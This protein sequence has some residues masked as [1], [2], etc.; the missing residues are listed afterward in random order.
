MAC[1]SVR[2]ALAISTSEQR[3]RISYTIGGIS[4]A[5]SSSS[6]RL[7]LEP[8][9]H[10]FATSSNRCDLEMAACWADHLEVPSCTPCFDSGGLW[11][12]YKNDHGLSFYF[13]TAHLGT[14]PYKK[15]EFNRAFTKGRISLLKGYFDPEMPIYPLEYPLDELL[16]IHRLSLGFGAEVHACGVLTNDGKGR[17]F[18]GHSGAGKSTTSRLWL[19]HAGTRI[20]SDD[21]IILRRQ[22]GQIHMYG[23][24]WHGDAGLAAQAHGAVDEIFLLEHGSKNEIVPMEKS[25]AAAELFAR[26]FVPHHSAAGLGNTLRFVEEIAC[27][28]PTYLFRFL[29]NSTAVEAILRGVA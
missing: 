13:Q 20:L 25:R 24:P 23:T 2:A 26:T 15:A 1:N 22:S 7:A 27:T 18:V 19:D 9:L 10:E 21:R 29:P 12:S 16:M 4:F 8:D 28:V 14:A 11:K 17:L 5:V 3:S 6:V